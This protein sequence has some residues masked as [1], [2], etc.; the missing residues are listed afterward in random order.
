MAT[1]SISTKG[2]IVVP[3]SFRKQDRIRPGEVF[4]VEREAPGVYRLLRQSQKANEG[5]VDWLLECPEKD[6]FRPIEGE[7]SEQLRS[8]FEPADDK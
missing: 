5:L 8:P 2:Q 6:W 4:S 3:A 1:T 7:Q